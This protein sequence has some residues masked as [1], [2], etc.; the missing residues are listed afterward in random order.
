[1][2]KWGKRDPTPRDKWR[3]LI[4][5]KSATSHKSLI[6]LHVQCCPSVLMMLTWDLSSD[7]LRSLGK[8]VLWGQRQREKAGC[9]IGEAVTSAELALCNHDNERTLLWMSSDAAKLRHWNLQLQ[10][11]FAEFSVNCHALGIILERG[12]QSQGDLGLELL[13]IV[14]W[15]TNFIVVL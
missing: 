13:F 9:L 1:M 12:L 15:V 8:G 11:P 5:S 2:L 7:S 10:C 3:I 14:G 6:L 4:E